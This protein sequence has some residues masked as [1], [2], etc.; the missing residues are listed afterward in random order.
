MFIVQG[1]SK[2]RG[3]S[4]F[5]TFCVIALEILHSKEYHSCFH[6][7]ELIVVILSIIDFLSSKRCSNYYYDFLH[8]KSRYYQ[9]GFQ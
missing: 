1:V 8:R 4:K 2:K 6:K 7:I 3:I 9:F 5:L